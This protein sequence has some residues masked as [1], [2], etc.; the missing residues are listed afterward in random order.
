MSGRPADS[1][2][3]AY[4]QFGVLRR[5]SRL[6]S[7]RHSPRAMRR[8][9]TL[10]ARRAPARRSGPRVTV[11]LSVDAAAESASSASVSASQSAAAKAAEQGAAAK[12]AAAE[13]SAAEEQAAGADGWYAPNGNWISP[14][15]AGR[16]MA[17]GIAPGETV[18][19]Y[20]RCGIICG[21]GPDLARLGDRRPLGEVSRGFLTFAGPHGS[22]TFRLAPA[23]SGPFPRS[24]DRQHCARMRQASCWL[25]PGQSI[26]PRKEGW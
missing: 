20:L 19:N 4:Q 17:A 25:P 12:S 2:V 18:P 23:F 15:T 14:E 7:C 21:E 6:R 5:S 22:M 16:A 8:R 11:T 9:R 26:P 13:R 24:F 3:N 10:P 1:P